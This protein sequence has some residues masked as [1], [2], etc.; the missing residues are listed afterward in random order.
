MWAASSLPVEQEPRALPESSRQAAQHSHWL[1]PAL[2]KP[3]GRLWATSPFF[4]WRSCSLRVA[5]KLPAANLLLLKRLLSLLQH[6]GHNAATS[7]MSC[8]NLAICVGPNL[9]SPPNEDL[10]PLEAL[11]EVTE[12]VRCLDG[13]A[14]AFP[15]HQSLAAQ[16]SLD[17]SGLE[18]MLVGWGGV[19]WGVCVEEQPQSHRLLRRSKGWEWERLLGPLSGSWLESKGLMCA[20]EGAGGVPGGELQGSLWGGDK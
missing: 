9:L 11:L 19:G 4:T 10:L 6:I 17:A 14:A 5:E 3:G 20:G 8:N 13:P 12:K 2:G 15:A 7:R 18:Q 1:P 16:R